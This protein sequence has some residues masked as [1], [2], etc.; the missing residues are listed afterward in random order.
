M[1]VFQ[2]LSPGFESRMC[3]LIVLVPGNCLSIFERGMWD[4][5]VLYP[6]HSLC[7]ASIDN[8]NLQVI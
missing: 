2:F 6:D 5:I 4:L 1:N 3:D 8:S 7:L